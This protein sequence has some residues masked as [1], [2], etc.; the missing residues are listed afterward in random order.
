MRHVYWVMMAAE[1]GAA[2]WFTWKIAKA[3]ERPWAGRGK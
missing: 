2:A 1:L 3:E